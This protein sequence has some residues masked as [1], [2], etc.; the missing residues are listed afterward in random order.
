MEKRNIGRFCIQF[1]NA[2]PRHLQVVELLEAQGRRKAQFIAE[3]VLHYINYSGSQEGYTQQDTDALKRTV[4]KI[5]R[6]Y[7]KA[8][9]DAS[10]AEAPV[11]SP[12]YVVESPADESMPGIGQGGEI[13]DDLLASIRESVSALRGDT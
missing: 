8:K 12:Q 13:D 9:P 3:A 4:E 1:N 10:A 11:I 2:D 7:L 6:E 5:V